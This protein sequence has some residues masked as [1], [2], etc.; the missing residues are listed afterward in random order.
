MKKIILF[1]LDGTVMNTKEGITKC[2][3]YALGKYDIKVENVDSLDFFVGPPLH[4]TF[5]DVY[6][7]DDEKSFKATE[8][9]RE[10]YKDI[11]IFECEP[12]EGIHKVLKEL[13]EKGY[14][15]GIAT[16]KAE[17]FA[18]R[19]IER[20]DLKKYFTHI[21]GSLMDNTRS[22]K[23]EVIEEAFKRFEVGSKYTKEEVV[24]VGDRLFDI[25]G[26]K[27]AGIDSV[28]VR[29]GFAKGDELEQAGADCVVNTPEEIIKAITEME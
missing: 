15:M 20:F 2:A 6:G 22:D 11:G 10:R 23:I 12:Y 14:L 1:D 7:M 16:S 17:L 18:E 25:I 19:I 8:F 28:G 29:Y 5:R 9:Y 24:M 4:T 13:Q 26:A 21:T 3:A 27:K